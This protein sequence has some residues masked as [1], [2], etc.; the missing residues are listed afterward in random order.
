MLLETTLVV[1]LACA[2]LVAP[3]QNI[4]KLNT[5]DI[6]SDREKNYRPG[7]DGTLRSAG[8][9]D[10]FRLFFIEPFLN[11]DESPLRLER[12]CSKIIFKLNT[13]DGGWLLIFSFLQSKNN[14]ML[15]LGN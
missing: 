15:Q 14:L 1:S 2:A 13:S 4:A 12:L 10:T 3:L 7:D 6:N 11:P 5:K 9:G 8:E